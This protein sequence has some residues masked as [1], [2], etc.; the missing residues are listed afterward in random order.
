MKTIIVVVILGF[1]YSGIPSSSPAEEAAGDK[2][3]DVAELIRNLG[4]SEPAERYRARAL[5]AG[6][7]EEAGPPLLAALKPAEGES[8]A[9][10]IEILAFIR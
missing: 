1:L 5:L 10:L 9:D 6:M 2:P 7:G 4:S 3:P 8:A